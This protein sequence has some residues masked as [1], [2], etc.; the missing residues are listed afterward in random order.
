MLASGR[1]VH[2]YAYGVRLPIPQPVPWS[3]SASDNDL[4]WM[5]EIH[6]DVAGWPD[7]KS[8][9]PIWIAPGEI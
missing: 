3:F 1:S 6:I 8:H 2:G 4:K 5:V 7:W 9:F